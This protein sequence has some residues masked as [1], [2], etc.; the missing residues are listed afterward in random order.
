[1]AEL[2]PTDGAFLLGPLIIFISFFFMKGIETT[3]I[4]FFMQTIQ[5]NIAAIIVLA[6]GIILLSIGIAEH[7][8]NIRGGSFML[9]EGIGLFSAILGFFFY[10]VSMVRELAGE[11]YTLTFSPLHFWVGLIIWAIGVFLITYA[12]VSSR[13]KEEGIIFLNALLT[14]ILACFFVWEFFLK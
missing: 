11:L 1:M 7:S 5:T 2:K 6:L 14:L 9:L 12:G 4:M 13:K 3:D 8:P 10:G